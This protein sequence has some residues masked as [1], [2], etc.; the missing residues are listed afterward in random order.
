MIENEVP[1][2]FY[3]PYPRI[4]NLTMEIYNQG[5][6]LVRAQDHLSKTFQGIEQHNAIEEMDAMRQILM[7]IINDATNLLDVVSGESMRL[8]LIAAN[9]DVEDEEESE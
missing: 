4:G 6:L 8:T 9:M 5:R 7:E 1:M 2:P 3:N